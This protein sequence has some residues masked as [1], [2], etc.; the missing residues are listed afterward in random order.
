MMSFAF[1]MSES[2]PTSTPAPFR[3]GLAVLIGRTN[4]GKS[5]LINSLVGA[6]VS[7]V[8]PRPQ[9]TRHPIHGIVHRPGGQVVFVDSPGFFKTHKSSLVDTLHQRAQESLKG[10]DVVVHVVDPTRDSGAENDMVNAILARVQQPRILCLSKLDIPERPFRDAWM[11]VA[12]EYAAV[13]E[14]SGITGE[15]TSQLVDL[16]L[17]RMPEGPE[18]YPAGQTTNTTIDF[19]A[20]ELIREKVYL[21]TGEEVPYRTQV[22]LDSIEEK[23]GKDGIP[24]VHVNAAIITPNERYQRM[25]IGTGA[26]KIRQIRLAAQRALRDRF[27]KKV[28][29]ELDVIIDRKMDS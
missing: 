19:Q 16:L 7:I 9:T 20:A 22:E 26:R 25:L 23:P 13:V 1:C 6:Q 12:S 29:L 11:R 21:Y 3:S 17:E 14:V 10:I 2:I 24:V 27:E 5:T 8:T 15:G 4:A 18:L 28:A